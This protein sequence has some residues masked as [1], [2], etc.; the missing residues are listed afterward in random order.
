MKVLI[1][2]YPYCGGLE[3]GRSIASDCQYNFIYDPFEIRPRVWTGIDGTEHIHDRE[4]NYGDDVPDNTLVVQNVGWHTR[5]PKN[6]NNISFLN[7]LKSKFNRVF[8]LMTNNIEINWKL[9]CSSMAQSDSTNY[10]WKKWNKEN[11]YEYEDSHFNASYKS[12]I[13]N[14]HQELEL[15]KDNLNLPVILKEDIFPLIDSDGNFEGVNLNLDPKG[16][17][18]MFSTLDIGMPTLD[19]EEPAGAFYTSIRNQWDNKF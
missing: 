3:I 5:N 19:L 10:W 4:Y 18:E 13:I 16:L 8:C 12:K 2:T 15:Y 9:Y 1:L 7:G 6:L 11:C 17:N 14:A